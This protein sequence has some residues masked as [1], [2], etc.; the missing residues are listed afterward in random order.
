M[1]W[2]AAVVGPVVTRRTGRRASDPIQLSGELVDMAEHR[3]VHE[4][5]L[6][7]GTTDVRSTVRRSTA[8]RPAPD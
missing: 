1:D 7:R 6:D 2:P 5:R 8:L 3:G 4:V